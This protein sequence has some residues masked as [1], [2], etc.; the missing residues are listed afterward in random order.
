MSLSYSCIN[1]NSKVIL[2]SVDSWGTNMNILRDPPKGIHTRQINRVGS[3]SNI[4]EMIDDSG[5]RSCEAILQYARG[6]N[7][8]VSVDYSNYGSNGG[9]RS[10]VFSNNGKQAYLPYRVVRDGSFRPPILSQY[11][12][13]PLSRMPRVFT[14]AMT[15]KGFSNYEKKVM[16]D[17]SPENMKEIKQDI[18]KSDVKSNASFIM[19][20]PII[21]PFELKYVIQ[22]P[23]IRTDISSGTRSLD[24][25]NVTNIEPSSAFIN[26]DNQHV[27]AQ[28]SKNNNIYVNN[29]GELNTSK[30][31][32]QDPQNTSVYSNTSSIN[33]TD[34][35]TQL[36]TDKYIQDITNTPYNTNATSNN[37]YNNITHLET[38]RF[39]QDKLNPSMQTV[40][41][42]SR[43]GFGGQNDL[44]TDKYVKDSMNVSAYTLPTS[45]VQLMSLEELTDLGGVH[46]KDKMNIDYTAPKTKGDGSKY[47]HDD[48]TLEKNLPEY[49]FTANHTQ[50][51]HKHVEIEKTHNLNR[52]MPVMTVNT[53]TNSRAMGVND[54]IVD[55]TVQLSHK[56]RPNEGFEGRST[57]PN[58]DRMQNGGESQNI[59]IEKQMMN[60]RISNNFNGR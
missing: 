60:K 10:S 15:N 33:G 7:P 14:Q 8:M 48:I 59:S 43:Y 50:N 32:I 3:T 40:A 53:N 9:Q 27:F 12:L 2:P 18:L 41:D 25:S 44:H 30:Y 51:I 54:N 49:N 57:I 23:I 35:I 4:T 56:I 26:K 37:H 55:R 58:P 31:I 19:Q 21:E 29:N 17:A 5:S 45:H 52:K 36:N 6:V 1:N 47:I 16:C 24:R 34:N 46:I 42:V 13:L 11:D 38:D 28:S 20:Q 39:I 22:N